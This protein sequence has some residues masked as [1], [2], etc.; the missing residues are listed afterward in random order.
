MYET[1]SMGTVSK[2]DPIWPDELIWA[3][4]LYWEHNKTDL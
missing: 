1:W 2:I 3:E 4:K